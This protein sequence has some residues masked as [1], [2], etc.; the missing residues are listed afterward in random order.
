MTIAQKLIHKREIETMRKNP[1]RYN[2]VDI[3][4]IDNNGT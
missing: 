4:S 2:I 1:S 3:S